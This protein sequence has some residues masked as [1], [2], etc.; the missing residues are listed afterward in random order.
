METDPDAGFAPV[1]LI[2]DDPSKSNLQLRS[3]RVLGSFDE[4]EEIAQS[5]N[6]EVLIVAIGRAD[7]AL[8]RSISDAGTRAGLTVKV[9]PPFGEMM[10]GVSSPSDVRDISIEDL[11]G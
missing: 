3:V 9:L 7:A 11:I 6:A 8:L 5:S 10:S 2:D 4:L 1:G